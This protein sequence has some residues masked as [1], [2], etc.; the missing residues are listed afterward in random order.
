MEEEK[1]VE[2][3]EVDEVEVDEDRCMKSGRRKKAGG[4]RRGIARIREW[5]ER[6]REMGEARA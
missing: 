1:K 6:W 3:E 2:M 5:I 4:E